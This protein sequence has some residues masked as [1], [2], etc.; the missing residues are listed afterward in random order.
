MTGAHGSS[1]K[2]HSSISAQVVGMTIV[3]GKG[4]IQKIYEPEDLKAFKV[5]LGLLG[6]VLK[7]YQNLLLFLSFEPLGIVVDVTLTTVPLYKVL[8]HNYIVSEDVLTNGVISN[9]A[10]TTDHLK[11]HWF[12]K[13]KE[14]V[15]LNLT[16]VPINTPGNAY[17]NAAS[18]TEAR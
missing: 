8:A 10:K 6:T 7:F 17:I 14:L 12:P 1:I 5:H 2:Y 3:N 15:V 11:L 13:F 18:D 16:F 9:W 4:Q